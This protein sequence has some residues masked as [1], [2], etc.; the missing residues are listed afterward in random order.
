MTI[1]TCQ[2]RAGKDETG[3]RCSAMSQRMMGTPCSS[4]SECTT[5]SIQLFYVCICFFIPHHHSQ[6]DPKTVPV[7]ANMAGKI[8][9]K[10][11]GVLVRVLQ[12]S[13]TDR[14]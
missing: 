3:E 10:K 4:W 9:S 2:I 6:D 1:E 8:N 7:T 11:E 13:R 14:M 12:R 5:P